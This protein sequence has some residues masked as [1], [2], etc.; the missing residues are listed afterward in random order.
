MTIPPRGKRASSVGGEEQ[1]KKGDASGSRSLG[2]TSAIQQGGFAV[3]CRKCVSLC[4]CSCDIVG[5][6]LLLVNVTHHS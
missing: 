2:T 3:L 4:D 5:K 1:V 6:N